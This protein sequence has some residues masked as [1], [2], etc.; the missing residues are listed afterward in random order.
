M[1]EAL[2][3]STSWVVWMLL[4]IGV[5]WG[6][7]FGALP[8]LGSTLA[9]TIIL[10]FTFG[11][12]ILDALVILIATYTSA[13]FGG[14]YSSILLC[15]PGTAGNLVTTFDGYPMSQQGKAGL[16]LGGSALSSFF[17]N[18]VSALLL[19]GIW[20]SY[21]AFGLKFGPHE[22]FMMALW[23]IVLTITVAS[24]NTYKNVIIAVVGF[25]ISCVGIHGLY[26]IPRLTFGSSYFLGGIPIIPALLGIFG[27]AI[28]LQNIA[29]EKDLMTSIRQQTP[30][31]SGF[32]A[33]GGGWIWVLI[34]SCTILGFIVGAIPGTGA[35][36]A[37]LLAYGVF[38]KVSRR[39]AE[40]GKGCFEG[41]VVAE[42]TNHATHPGA[43][44]TTLIVGVPGATEMVIL[45]GAF[46]LHGLRCGPML[47]PQ[48]P[49]ILYTIF[50]TLM[51]SGFFSLVVTWVTLKG[52]VKLIESPK[53]FL[54]PFILLLCILGAYTTRNNINDVLVMLI[55]GVF[56]FACERSG[57]SKIVLLMALVLGPIM[58]YNLSKALQLTSPY[59]FFTRPISMGLFAML[60]V[61]VFVFLRGLRTTKERS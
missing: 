58:E 14:S 55:L 1:T 42:T 46:T 56:T 9:M 60:V 3:L 7:F 32:K 34:G 35:L 29:G 6:L 41:V 24:G 37:T 57:F 5:L 18:T 52:W 10:P 53:A 21:V 61:M 33:F 23:G 4:V 17:G 12:P 27:V 54:W 39:G 13:M 16:A 25:V 19:M 26:G 43:I 20:G 36:V 40:Y 50:L 28:V 49:E 8:G 2:G 30:R 44:L 59:G 48:H 47:L 38:K 45:L 51:I 31:L 22:I 11:M 15:I